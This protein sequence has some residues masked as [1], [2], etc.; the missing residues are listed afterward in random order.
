MGV[1]IDIG[2]DMLELDQAATS[3]LLGQHATESA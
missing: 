1:K 3:N 2:A